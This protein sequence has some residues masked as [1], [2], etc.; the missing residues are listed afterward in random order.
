MADI[1]NYI[2]Y[3]EITMNHLKHQVLSEVASESES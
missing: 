2:K 3:D 1:E